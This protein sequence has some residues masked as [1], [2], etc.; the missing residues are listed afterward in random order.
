M[1]TYRFFLVDAEHRRTLIG[2]V[3][4]WDDAAATAKATQLA[5]E[6]VSGD[7]EIWEGN[8]LVTHIPRVLPDH[9]S[10]R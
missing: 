8:R 9:R 7:L 6:D 2:T 3:R 4:F 5:S 1:R 10:A